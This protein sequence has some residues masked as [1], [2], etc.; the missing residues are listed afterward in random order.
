MHLERFAAADDSAAVR[1]AHEIYLAGVPAD[2]PYGPPMPARCFAGWLALGW[3]EDPSETWLA[4]DGAGKA[5][6]WYV[7]GLPQRENRHLASVIPWVHPGQR[8]AGLGTTLVRHAAQRAHRLGRTVLVADARQGSP[9]AAFAHALGARQG[10]TQVRRV[11]DVTAVAPGRLAALRAAAQAAARGYS[12]LT[13]EGPAPEDQFA[14]IAAVNTALADMPH[15]AGQEA[16]RWDAERVRLDEHRVATQGLR[17]Y[18][19][20]ARSVATG[21]LAALSQLGVDPADPT[22]GHQEVTAVTRPHRGHRLGL[23]VK[24]AMLELLAGR[25]PQLTRIITGNADGNRHMIAI[26]DE[27]GFTV[28]DRWPSWEIE[29]AGALAPSIQAEP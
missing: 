13:W 29:V 15:E 25:E 12:L 24:V 9:G 26:N 7:L 18:T 20:A 3:T 10:I 21:E 11:L 22:W 23:L 17:F 16:Q 4:R 27:L 8:R 1:A 14:A 28:L 2:D 5:C 19:V 6:G